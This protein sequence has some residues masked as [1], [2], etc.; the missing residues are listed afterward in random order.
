MN[1]VLVGEQGDNRELFLLTVEHGDVI[2]TTLRRG[3]PMP[4]DAGY[5]EKDEP[6]WLAYEASFEE[7]ERREEEA[8]ADRASRDHREPA[9]G[10]AAARGGADA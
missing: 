10:N 1:G 3:E 4:W 5:V 7:L 6:P 2:R 9:R 8:L